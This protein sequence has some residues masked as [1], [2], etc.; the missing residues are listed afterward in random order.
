MISVTVRTRGYDQWRAHLSRH[1]GA[2]P[3][4]GGKTVRSAQPDGSLGLRQSR[5]G[6]TCGKADIGDPR[7]QRGES[8]N[9]RFCSPAGCELLLPLDGKEEERIGSN[10][11]A[12]LLHTSMG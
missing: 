2:N 7:K 9:W 3:A 1:R 5:D 11:T 6:R 12:H 10:R 8:A 4:S